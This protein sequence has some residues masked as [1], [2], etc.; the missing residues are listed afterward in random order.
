MSIKENASENIVYEKVVILSQWR[1]VKELCICLHYLRI[2]ENK[3]ALFGM[4]KSIS[5]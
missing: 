2:A 5:Q 3:H 4:L 1:W